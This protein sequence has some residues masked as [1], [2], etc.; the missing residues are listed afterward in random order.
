MKRKTRKT[1]S[2]LALPLANDPPIQWPA[3][4]VAELIV[5]LADLLIEAHLRNQGDQPEEYAHDEPK[6]HR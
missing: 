5:A 6:N 1:R 3:P 2:Q 4:T